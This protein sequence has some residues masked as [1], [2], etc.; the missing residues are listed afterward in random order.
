MNP[1]Q[2]SDSVLLRTLASKQ[3]QTYSIRRILKDIKEIQEN[4]IP[5]VGVSAIPSNDNLYSW[6]CNIK[7]P[8]GTIYQGKIFKLILELPKNYPQSPPTV[9]IPKP[10]PHPNIIGSHICVDMLE[11]E[12]WSPAYSVLSVLIQLQSFLFKQ[13]KL[14]ENKERREEKVERL[15]KEIE[16][17]VSNSPQN[18]PIKK[19]NIKDFYQK[20][21]EDLLYESQLQCFHSKMNYDESSLGLGLKISRY[22]RTRELSTCLPIPEFISL[23]SF[24]KQGIRKGINKQSFG[25]FLPLYFKNEQKDKVLHLA[26]RGISFI[27]TNSPKRFEPE[28]AKKVIFKAMSS[29]FITITKNQTYPSINILRQFVSLHQLI[30]LFTEKYPEIRDI[31]DQ[32]IKSFL[33]SEENRTKNNCSNLVNILLDLLVSDK[34]KFSDV[35]KDY[36]YEQLDRQVF[37]ILQKIPELE[38]DDANIVIDENRSKVTFMSQIVG[39]LLVMLFN[40]YLEVTQKKYKKWTNMFKRLEGT[41]AKLPRR[42]EDQ[43]Q[44]RFKSSLTQV[45][46]YDKYFQRIGMKKLRPEEIAQALKKAVKRSKDKK[47]HGCLEELLKLPESNVQVKNYFKDKDSFQ[48]VLSQETDKMVEENK[49][50]E[51]WKQKCIE[52]FEIVKNQITTLD[53][54]NIEYS[55]AE[56]AKECDELNYSTNLIQSFKKDP[57]LVLSSKMEIE[58]SE[59]HKPSLVE[60]YPQNFTWRQLFAKL[61]LERTIL[62]M[63]L[64]LDF[65]SFYAKLEAVKDLIHGLSIVISP[66]N[67]IKSGYYFICSALSKL[68][69]MKHLKISLYKVQQL[70]EKMMKSIVKGLKNFNKSGGEL[71][72]ISLL[73]LDY[74]STSLRRKTKRQE[75]INLEELFETFFKC[76]GS[77]KRFDCTSSKILQLQSGELLGQFLEKNTNLIEINLNKSL[78]NQ[79]VCEK[80][81]DGLMHSRKIRSITLKN[82]QSNGIEKILYNLSFLPNLVYLNLTEIPLTNLSKAIENLE[83]LL[84]INPFIEVLILRDIPTL[85]E[86]LNNK[87]FKSLSRNSSLKAIDF[88]LSESISNSVGSSL[89][90]S[91][92]QLAYSLG[93]NNNG[94][95]NLKHLYLKNLNIPVDLLFKH[96]YTSNQI[97]ESVFGN[98]KTAEAMVGEDRVKRHNIKLETLNLEGS[99]FKK[100][101]KDNYKGF[102]LDA[103]KK[104]CFES[105]PNW[106]NLFL[107]AKELRNLSLSDCSLSQSFFEIL[108]ALYTYG[109]ENGAKPQIDNLELLD[110]SENSEN[111]FS[112]QLAP[113]LKHITS[114]KKLNLGNCEMSVAGLI[115]LEEPLKSTQIEYL[116]LFANGIDVDGAIKMSRVLEKNS[117]LKFLDIGYNRIRAKGLRSI[118]K[119]INKSG[120]QGLGL[121]F[122]HLKDD[123]IQELITE[124]SQAKKAKL[125]FLLIKNNEIDD[126]YLEKISKILSEKSREDLK[127]DLLDKVELHLDERLS[128]TIWIPSEESIYTV[129]N[130]LQNQKDVGVVMNIR[131]RKSKEYENKKGENESIF[132][133]F[134]NKMSVEKVIGLV[135][136]KKLNF[137]LRNNKMVGVYRAGTSTFSYNK[138]IGR[139]IKK[140][141]E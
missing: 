132:V 26:E 69:N 52:N 61:D 47:Y 39:Y 32:E 97:E 117:S 73:R 75:T 102:K 31:C 113:L 118:T 44:N 77:V 14:P 82:C 36:F 66:L 71:D 80:L 70:N 110:L 18:P 55:P 140:S 63:H 4:K 107:H 131:K 109:S 104:N 98:M 116:N 123:E 38:D 101:F 115:H 105:F 126:Y 78:T 57:A 53:S 37:W 8:K 42:I 122:N 81:A 92:I 58:D 85:F 51:H 88:S 28:M 48:D 21:D 111:R 94:K 62:F 141:K 84:S 106:V 96:Y 34:Y 6:N 16:L 129:K 9:T 124:I 87:F 2:S 121:R 49:T 103:V 17:A 54:L 15:K 7:G 5:T 11:E 13:P 68:T 86:N 19:V 67:K 90:H 136:G 65:K 125:K 59:K 100:V 33:D 112:K 127:I 60:F 134:A 35:I 64:E 10:F 138:S 83:R 22:P 76:I 41:F 133:E 114:L 20:N 50:E 24:M 137:G 120:L 79:K 12:K 45:F 130:K 1:N 99:S 128:R 135:S 93:I 108:N 46:S 40:D 43:I 56:L 25:Y 3:A 72:S 95:G 27:M 30:L 29:I 23:R 139:A 89:E 74:E 119:V 91:T